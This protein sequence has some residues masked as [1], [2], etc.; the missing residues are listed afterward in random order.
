MFHPHKECPI[1]KICKHSWNYEDSMC[2]NNLFKIVVRSGN[3]FNIAKYFD[4][5][6]EIIL[7]INRFFNSKNLEDKPPISKVGT[8]NNK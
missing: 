3:S 6:Q 4:L 7:K 2:A 5:I 1:L 8:L